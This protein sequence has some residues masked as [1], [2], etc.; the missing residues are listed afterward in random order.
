MSKEIKSQ[1]KFR[2]LTSFRDNMDKLFSEF[3]RAG[4]E[5]EIAA[6]NCYDYIH[7][8]MYRN[9]LSEFSAEMK[10]LKDQMLSFAKGEVTKI[11]IAEPL[12]NVMVKV[13]AWILEEKAKRDSMR[14]LLAP[15]F[16]KA[17]DQLMEDV[18]DVVVVS[19]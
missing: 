13:D 5:C 8:V 11:S 10:V 14:N 15:I 2:V 16:K 6:Q 9:E 19:E 17:F 4:D 18:L 7:D 3:D 12:A 1:T